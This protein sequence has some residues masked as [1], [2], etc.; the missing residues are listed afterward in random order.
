MTTSRSFRFHTLDVFTTSRFGG[1]P[2]AVVPDADGLT[3]DEMQ[4]IAREFNLSE[5]TFVLPPQAGGTQRVRIFTPAAELPFAGHPTVGTALLLHG[6]TTPSSEQS[7]FVFEEGVGPVHVDVR[8]D[9]GSCFAELQVAQPV[10]VRPVLLDITELAALVSVTPADIDRNAPA[11]CAASVGLPFLVL[12][13]TDVAALGRAGLDNTRWAATLRGTW[14]PQIYLYVLQDGREGS[15]VRVRMFSP[16]LGVVED[17]ATGSAA[18]A[19]AAFMASLAP[20][21]SEQH[22]TIS[23]GIELGRP[24]TLHARFAR[25]TDGKA[26]IFVGGHAVRISEGTLWL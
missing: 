16:A 12:P 7:R 15:N 23:Q 6:L 11:P 20:D 8:C 10:E 26:N 13:L 14:A 25:G 24:S 1:N 18:A 5:T 22:W 3:S 2:L 4:S 21:R 17:P 9:R 19:F